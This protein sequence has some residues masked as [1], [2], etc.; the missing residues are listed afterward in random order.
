MTVFE[1]VFSLT[2]LVLSLS[3]V[4]VLMGLGKTLRVR[5]NLHV[6]WLT[7]ILGIFVL[8]DV[9]TFW[10]MAW[11]IRELMPSVWPSLGVG[12]V[13][14]GVYYVAA[15]LVFPED[16]AEEPDLE[17]YYWRNKRTVIG[18]L[19]GCNLAA[20]GIG[21][22]LGRSWSPTVTA[23]NS[24]YTAGLLVALFAPGKLVNISALLFLVA[25]QVWSFSTP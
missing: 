16:F 9:T 13:L 20:F 19:L 18:L 1:M 15:S 14:T 12:L 10:G 6:G 7:P 25:V 5:P 3:L 24:L 8:G 23:I 2:G 11:E 22:A 21:L 17:A 4:V